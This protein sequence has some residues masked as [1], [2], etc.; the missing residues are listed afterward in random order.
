MGK[1]EVKEMVIKETKNAE[2]RIDQ[3]QWLILQVTLLIEELMEEKELTRK[4]LADRLGTNKSYV[5]QLLDGYNMTLK[6]V[7]DVMSALDSSLVVDTQPV[8]FHSN[9]E[10]VEIESFSDAFDY[11][12]YPKFH[13]TS[14]VKTGTLNEKSCKTQKMVG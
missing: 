5:T 14:N 11:S 12:E 9:I 4:Q 10:P 1:S 2:S 8:G 3:Q 7:A 13:I 6:K